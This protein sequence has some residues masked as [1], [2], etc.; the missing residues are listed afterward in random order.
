[1]NRQ[2]KV[3]LVSHPRMQKPKPKFGFFNLAM[4]DRME[5]LRPNLCKNRAYPPLR[6]VSGLSLRLI[7]NASTVHAA[8]DSR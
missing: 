1:M 4:S 6:S 7:H 3:I 5:N 2:P 8:P